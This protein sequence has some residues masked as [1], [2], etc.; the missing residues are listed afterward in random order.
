MDFSTAILKNASEILETNA[1]R[2][3]NIHIND[4]VQPNIP[5]EPS[6]DIVETRN[7]NGVIYVTPATKDFYLTNIA[8]S[9]WN[10]A[11]EPTAGLVTLGFYDRNGLQK[12]FTVKG[13]IGGSPG[14]STIAINFPKRGVLLAKNT[15]ITISCSLGTALIAGYLWSDRSGL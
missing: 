1:I 9:C 8:L 14:Q 10:D 7:D 11:S 4:T 13:D 6:I 12:I 3:N 15:N 5:I 2:N